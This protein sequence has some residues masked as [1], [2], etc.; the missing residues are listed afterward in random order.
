MIIG[1]DLDGVLVGLKVVEFATNKTKDESDVQDYAYS[2]FTEDIRQLIFSYFHD[3]VM[4]CE[5]IK[6][7]DGVKE[8]LDAWKSSGHTLFLITARAKP[9]REATLK[10]VER[11]FGGIFQDVRF[12]NIDENK[13]EVLKELG[14]DIFIDDAPHNVLAAYKDIPTV[15][16]S[17]KY[18]K[19]NHHLREQV[20]WV[21]V[22]SDIN[23]VDFERKI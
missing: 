22:I 7:L 15:M 2:H 9:I 3:P 16:V 17:N 20:K 10:M 4:M 18:T 5:K 8:T 21:K 23:L 6:V 1:C 14:V 13:T 12:V 19:Y 11:L